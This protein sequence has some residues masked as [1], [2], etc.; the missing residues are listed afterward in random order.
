MVNAG[1]KL[2]V[3][4]A[5][6]GGYPAAFLAADRGLDVTL[7]D[8]EPNPG[9][10]CLY[11][12]CI[13]SKALLH[14]A[15]VL[16]E[17]REA[18]EWGMQFSSPTIDLDALRSWKESVVKRLT[19]GLGLIRTQRK[20]DH[21]Q[22]YGRFVD[23]QSLNVRRN[24]EIV[25]VQFD[26]AIIATGSVPVIPESLRLKSPRVMDSTA[27]LELRDIPPRLLVIGGG[28]IGLELGTVYA[29]L[30]SHVTVVEMTSGLLPGVDRDLVKPLADRLKSTFA[31][32]LLNT[33]VTEMAEVEGGI[34]VQLSG[35]DV[36]P[37]G[38]IYDEVLVAVGRRPNSGDLGLDKIKVATDAKGFIT[39][40][41]QLR[42]NVPNIYAI[43]DVAGEPMLAHEATHAA[44]VAVEAICGDPTAFD[45][46][47]I[48]AVVFTDPE[49]AW[50]GPTENQAREQGL[51]FEVARFPWRASGRATTLGRNEG[52]TKL[53]L[54]RGTERVLGVGISGVGA[55]DLIAE[56][57]LAIEMGARAE[58]LQ[59]TI[60]AHPTLSETVMESAEVFFGHS[61]HFVARPSRH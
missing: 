14:V 10:V 30:G 35:A 58:D 50:C 60:H 52:V 44:R 37:A 47:A 36:D 27:A 41:S 39:T 4:G 34:E 3:L 23:V 19:D 8:A 1:Q 51:E 61:P 26:T 45:P 28:Y 56:G 42:T 49:I 22:G 12:G 55:G 32:I 18:T 16:H 38:R 9:G 59:R 2:V 6:P 33:R 46:Q 53:I 5:G 17:T 13:P 15:R 21:V 57:V 7:V 24:G 29:A 31:E 40:D 25:E 11:R 48:P 43:G 54:E 20:V